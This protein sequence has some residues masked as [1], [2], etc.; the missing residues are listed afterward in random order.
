MAFALWLVTDKRTHWS[1][2]SADARA[3]VQKGESRPLVAPA[4]TSELPAGRGSV[5]PSSKDRSAI[6]RS[7]GT[8]SLPLLY[9]QIP[10]AR[11]GL[12]EVVCPVE[13]AEKEGIGLEF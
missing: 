2:R 8:G 4:T 10:R 9:L 6:E 13:F 11:T 7:V 12:Q 5:E 1:R 3:L